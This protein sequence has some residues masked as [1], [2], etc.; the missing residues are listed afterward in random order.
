MYVRRRHPR[1]ACP[2]LSDGSA[3][4]RVPGGLPIVLHLADD[5]ESQAL[6]LP[7]WQREEMT[8]V[9]GE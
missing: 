2:S 3:H 5:S 8:F 4:F 6:N 1:H 9:P 7:R